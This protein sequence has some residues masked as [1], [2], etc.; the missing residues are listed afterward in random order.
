MFGLSLRASHARLHRP[1]AGDARRARRARPPRSRRARR[2]DRL[3]LQSRGRLP[4]RRVRSTPSSRWRHAS[5]ASARRSSGRRSPRASAHALARASC[6]VA[7]AD[8]RERPP[9]AG[10]RPAR[11]SSVAPIAARKPHVSSQNGRNRVFHTACSGHWTNNTPKHDRDDEQHERRAAPVPAGGD[12]RDAGEQP[13]PP[14]QPQRRRASPVAAASSRLRETP[15]TSPSI[16]CFTGP[17]RQHQYGHS[18]HSRCR[19]EIDL[20]VAHALRH[21]PAAR[22][23]GS[24]HTAVSADPTAPTGDGDRPRATRRAASARAAPRR[25]RRRSRRRCAT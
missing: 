23:S 7:V 4:A 2:V 10:R 3:R 8:P 22:C 24:D 1:D 15:R 9:H 18:S 6:E 20:R 25:R 12:D 17:G 5:S 19:R 16:V 14:R 21:T 13:D 11:S